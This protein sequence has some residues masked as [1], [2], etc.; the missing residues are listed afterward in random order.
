M[1]A[2]NVATFLIG[3]AMF[4]A[5]ALIP[6]FVQAP[7]STGY[8]FG[9]S[10][11]TAGLL[12]LPS[13]L[14]QLVVGPLAGRLGARFGF[15]VTLVIGRSSSVVSYV[16][17]VVRHETAFELLVA[18]IFLGAGVAFGFASMANLIVAAVPQSDV[19]I[20]TGINTI[21]RTAGG[22]FGSAAVTAIL[23][24]SVAA[25]TGL[26]TEGGY[27]AAFVASVVV[28]CWRSSP[29]G[30][31]RAS[32]GVGAR[33][34]RRR[35]VGP[36]A[37]ELSA[38]ARGAHAAEAAPSR[39]A[40]S[41]ATFAERGWAA[42]RCASPSWCPRSDPEDLGQCPRGRRVLADDVEEDPLAVRREAGQLLAGG[43]DDAGGGGDVLRAG[44]DVAEQPLH[45]AGA[46]RRRAAVAVGELRDLVDRPRDVRRARRAGACSGGWRAARR[47]SSVAQASRQDSKTS[48]RAAR[49][50]ASAS[51][52]PIWKAS[53]S[54]I[55]PARPAFDC[56]M[57]AS[58][59]RMRRPTPSAQ[60]EWQISAIWM[61]PSL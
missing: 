45:R 1:L 17:L 19:G 28:G 21:M 20:A 40:P 7:E 42:S 22:A 32:A 9:D 4:A 30:S 36:R 8:G 11:T 5:F 49:N 16:M 48:A 13:A 34:G 35:V 38:T 10:V 47:L 6:R 26:P 57:P 61:M 24:G 37:R 46:Q 25:D 41:R 23:T 2:T 33:A 55:C 3:F 44:V 56:A 14:I 52:K 31:C 50:F 60:P 54:A 12:L 51:A 59:S 39:R 18:G 15:R 58:S 27:T 53:L 43:L 29:R